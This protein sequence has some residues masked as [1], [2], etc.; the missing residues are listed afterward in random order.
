MD[1]NGYQPKDLFFGANAQ[2]KLANGINKM[3]AAVKS[4]LGPRGNTV[5]IESPMHTHGI[6]VTKDG[7][8]VAKSI[9]LLD[10]VENLAVRMMK[11]AADK[12]ATIAGDGTTTAI[13]LTEGL[14]VAGM[15]ALNSHPD[16][17]RALFL[18][19]LNS[20]ATDIAK[21]VENKA[22]KVDENTL[23]NV[24]CISA[25]ND[26]EI[27]Q[28]IAEVYNELGPN[29][30]V[31][32]EK[33]QTSDTTIET[34]KGI[35]VERGFSSNLFINDQKK[36][37]CV[38]EDVMVMVSDMEISNV[39]QIENVLKPVIQEGKKLLMIAPC[40]QGVINTIAANVMK[41]GLKICI[42]QP[43]SFG[44]KQQELMQDIAVSVGATYF[45]EGTGDDLS[46]MSY[47][48]LG[49]AHKCIVGRDTTI[50]L[51][52]E[53]KA[54]PEKVE[55]RIEQL[56]GAHEAASKKGDKD[57]I[58][59]R[60]ASLTGGI[61]VIK[62]GGKTDLEQKELYD[63]VDDAVCAVRS[64]LE[65]GVVAGGGKTLYNEARE[66]SDK[67]SGWKGETRMAAEVLCSALV[68]PIMQIMENGGMW[69]DQTMQKLN[70]FNPEIGYNVA[71]GQV[72]NLMV[73]GIIDPAKV[74]INA[75]GN[76][77]SVATTI[78]STNA[79]V[80]MARAFETK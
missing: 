11:E 63:R 19:E 28:M 32:V 21:R 58:M 27:G 64:A 79:I 77:M 43:P 68:T 44:Y 7:V 13:V 41:N 38:F 37:E 53:V 14:V 45:S 50:L 36:D 78:L 26:E 62:V 46:L 70:E 55:E 29:G 73:S 57:F 2:V 48:D 24:A 65:M 34:T 4:T 69:S 56:K 72:C 33:S 25:N 10:P 59:E 49:H 67:L 39:L 23:L 75:L 9:D 12:T 51:K 3:A 8:T 52:S 47:A 61:G 54:D 18:K 6:T 30:I 20:L 1:M 74:T 35:K 5:L 60:I 31:T 17:N 66:L 16:M 22:T 76:A 71:T 40:N 42:I 80:T 15:D